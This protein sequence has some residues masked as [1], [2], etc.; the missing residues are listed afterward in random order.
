M[1]ERK[2]RVGRPPTAYTPER[3]DEI[4]R[5]I[6][7]AESLKTICQDVGVHESTVYGW[8]LDDHEG[9]GQRYARA[10][11]LM[12]LKWA[13]EL[14][15]IAGDRRDDF[16]QD[17]DG[18]WKPDYEVI[19]RS[20]LRIDTRKWVLAKMLP[21]VYGDRIVTE[22]T[23]K[24]GAALQAPST[25][26]NVLALPPEQRE[27]LKQILLQATKGKSEDGET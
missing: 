19:A 22:L 21:K 20:K 13:D 16:K 26:I 17:E 23:G 27:Q 6:S 24:D 7:E 3:A 4:L 12:A 14:D 18:K 11:H 1:T 5:R 15:E 9:F 2:R 10:K 25:T 8:V